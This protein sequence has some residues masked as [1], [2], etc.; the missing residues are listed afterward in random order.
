MVA[1]TITRLFLFKSCIILEKKPKKTVE[2][3][4][5]MRTVIHRRNHIKIVGTKHN[6]KDLF[7]ATL[8]VSLIFANLKT[9]RNSPKV[10]FYSYIYFS[11]KHLLNY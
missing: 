2:M 10:F 9:L 5:I 8:L 7:L 4:T 3:F 6:F 11:S 1:S